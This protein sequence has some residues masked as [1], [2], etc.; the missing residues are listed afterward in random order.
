[1]NQRLNL[2]N[3]LFEYLQAAVPVVVAEGTAHCQLVREHALGRCVDV[4][5]PAAVARSIAELLAADPDERARLRRHAR[6]VALAQ[7][8]WEVQGLNVIELYR[9]IGR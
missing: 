2:A 8:T 9:R 6:T 3:K 7:Y 4:D 5:D 1:L